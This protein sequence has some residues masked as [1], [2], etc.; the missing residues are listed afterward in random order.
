MIELEFHIPLPAKTVWDYLTSNEHLQKWWGKGVTLERRQDG[1]FIEPWTDEK[2]KKRI[3]MGRVTAIE[4]KKRLQLDWQDPSWI[5]PTR[6]EFLLSK[7]HDGTRVYLQHSGWDIF[8]GKE[9]QKKVDAHQAGW[10]QLM[11]KFRQYCQNA[12]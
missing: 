12:S 4:E 10:M 9:R 7:T 6:V 5:K 3:T 8:S 1:N 2:G 11:E